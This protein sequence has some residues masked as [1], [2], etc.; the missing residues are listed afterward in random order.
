M[1]FSDST[2]NIPQ[3]EAVPFSRQASVQPTDSV[4]LKRVSPLFPKTTFLPF[5]QKPTWSEINDLR[6]HR[7]EHS[8]HIKTYLQLPNDLSSPL[9]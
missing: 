5:L 9:P 2:G 6:K 3:Y 4:L 8:T 1:Y 7:P